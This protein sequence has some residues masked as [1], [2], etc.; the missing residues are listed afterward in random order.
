MQMSVG[1]SWSF[2]VVGYYRWCWTGARDLAVKEEKDQEKRNN[3][4]GKTLQKSKII[5]M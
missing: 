1:W 5:I 2:Y 3:S 4:Y